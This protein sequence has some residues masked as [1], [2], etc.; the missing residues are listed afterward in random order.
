MIITLNSLSSILLIFIS[1]RPLAVV[2]LGDVPLCV[3]FSV[4]GKSATSSA[5]EANDIMKKRSYRAL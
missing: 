2:H 3:C 5:L 4:L 1:V